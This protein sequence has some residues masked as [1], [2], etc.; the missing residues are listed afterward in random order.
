MYVLKDGKFP[1]T[2]HNDIFSKSGSYHTLVKLDEENKFSKSGSYDELKKEDIIHV[3]I[4]GFD[5]DVTNNNGC[6]ITV[7]KVEFDLIFLPKDDRDEAKTR[8][9]K[10]DSPFSN[11]I[12]VKIKNPV[13]NFPYGIVNKDSKSPESPE[14][15]TLQYYDNNDEFKTF[16]MYKKQMTI[17]GGI[18]RRM[19]KKCKQTTMKRKKRMKRKK[20]YRRK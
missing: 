18:T 10:I 1:L 15:L 8:F 12:A 16:D 19:K 6:N 3:K 14:Y 9:T 5:C 17:S 2:D 11:E 4:T 20:S 13:L 7:E